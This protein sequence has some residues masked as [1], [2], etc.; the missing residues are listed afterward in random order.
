[1]YLE[2]LSIIVV[3]HQF[4][5]YVHYNR[6]L[7]AT[8]WS[9]KIILVEALQFHYAIYAARDQMQHSGSHLVKWLASSNCQNS[10]KPSFNNFL[11]RIKSRHY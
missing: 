1:M 2:M 7:R 3:S 9:A 5:I 8:P 10:L 4:N 6:I 11:V